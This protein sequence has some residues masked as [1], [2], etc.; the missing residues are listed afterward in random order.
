MKQRGAAVLGDMTLSKFLLFTGSTHCIHDPELPM[1]ARGAG[2]W[3]TKL[4]GDSKT[5]T[6]SAGIA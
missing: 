5:E 6:K 2:T 3:E 1:E 4:K